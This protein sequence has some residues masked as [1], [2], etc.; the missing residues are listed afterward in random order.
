MVQHLL[1]TVQHLL[2]MVQHLLVMVQHLLVMV[3]HLLEVDVFTR[4][5]HKCIRYK[6]ILNRWEHFH[7]VASF[8]AHIYVVNL[9]AFETCRSL[10]NGEDV[11]SA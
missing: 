4:R 1:V 8:T 7:D 3:Q 10:T 9:F 11:C 2:V 5:H 6:V